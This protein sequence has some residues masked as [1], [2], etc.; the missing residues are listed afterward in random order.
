METMKKVRDVGESQY[1]AFR[2]LG[3]NENLT[4]VE[5]PAQY[6][7]QLSSHD[8][9][10]PDSKDVRTLPYELP[11]NEIKLSILNP[12]WAPISRRNENMVPP[13]MEYGEMHQPS[14]IED[15]QHPCQM[16]IEDPRTLNHRHDYETL[17]EN[18]PRVG[19]SAR[20]MASQSSPNEE[21]A[22]AL[23]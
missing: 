16:N 3:K 1:R 8:R 21:L 22:R 2:E 10:A 11:S 4:S 20:T 17:I 14:R 12:V 9:V 18:N 7:E 15:L 6:C 23:R 5:F 13:V 19:K